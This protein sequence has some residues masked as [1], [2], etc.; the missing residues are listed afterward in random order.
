MSKLI[1]STNAS[2]DG[3]IENSDGDFNFAVPSAE[4]HQFFNDEFRDVGTHVYGRKLY[5]TMAVWETMD[6][7]AEGPPEMANLVEPG[8]DFQQIWRGADKI[9]YSTTLDEVWTPRTE[10]RSSFDAEEIR[11]FVDSADSDVI[12]GGADL[13]ASAFAA[14]L[15]DEISITLSPVAIGAGKPALPTDL[16]LNLDLLKERRFDNGAVNVQYKVN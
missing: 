10:L 11:A 5:E 6:L 4:L 9:V 16:V 3:F 8:R 13:A 7:E 12:I 14:G 1:Y 2:L 15:I